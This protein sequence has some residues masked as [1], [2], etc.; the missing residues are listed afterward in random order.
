MRRKTIITVI[1]L[2]GIVVIGTV[3]AI[4]MIEKS[5]YSTHGGDE[6][7]TD[8]TAALNTAESEQKPVLLYFWMEN[9]ASCEQFDK[10]MGESDYGPME[11]FVLS[12]V[13]LEQRPEL[14]TRYN[15]TGTPT[16]VILDAEGNMVKKFIPTQTNDVEET[17]REGYE[18][19]QN[20]TRST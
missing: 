10:Q 14:S 3:S 20:Q 13:R 1:F 11:H 4:G 19:W 12:A 2:L 16:M 18:A 5:K 7:R 9:C 6:W 8:P 17:L 15:V